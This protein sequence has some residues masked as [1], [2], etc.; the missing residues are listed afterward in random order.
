M[1]VE[2]LR[3]LQDLRPEVDFSNSSDFVNDGHLDSFDI[4]GL[5]AALEVQYGV[6]IDGLEVVPNNFCNI[7]AIS[8]LVKRSPSS[9]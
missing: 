2:I 9:K 5:V 4:I 8:E 1:Q 3:I 7:T 6:K